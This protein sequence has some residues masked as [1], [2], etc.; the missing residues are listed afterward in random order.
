MA[1]EIKFDKTHKC[2][3][4]QGTIDNVIE[5]INCYKSFLNKPYKQQLAEKEAE[6]EKTSNIQ[7]NED[8]PTAVDLMKE[9]VEPNKTNNDV[10]I[11][12]QRKI[13]DVVIKFRS[14]SFYAPASYDKYKA[15]DRKAINEIVDNHYELFLQYVDEFF[16]KDK[17]YFPTA[18]KPKTFIEKLYK[19]QNYFIRK[20]KKENGTIINVVEKFK[21]ISNNNTFKKEEEKLDSPF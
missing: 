6:Y 2:S 10:D 16:T 11:E 3:I 13:N 20:Q 21:Q 17:E 1:I 19:I 5:I 18:I 12:R 4:K 7:L 8:I 15:E 9:F 14:L